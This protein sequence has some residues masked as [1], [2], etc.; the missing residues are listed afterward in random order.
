MSYTF[1]G[2]NK[3]ITLGGVTSLNLIDLYSRWKDWVSSDN[4]K[5]EQAFGTVGGEIDAIPLYLFLMNGWRIIPMASNHTL[6][7]TDGILEVAE[8]GDPFIDPLGS[9]KIRINRQTPGIAI[10]YTIDSGGG[11][12]ANVIWSHPKALTVAKFIGLK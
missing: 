6:T 10:G 8:G 1:D 3:T 12:D 5:Y 11:T 9:Y 2:V 7:V 4:A